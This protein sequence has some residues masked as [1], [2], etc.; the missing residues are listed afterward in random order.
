MF[1][2]LTT[3]RYLA[4]PDA[5]DASVQKALAGLPSV[6]RELRC[7]E[8]VVRR[9]LLQACDTI[10]DPQPNPPP[11]A[12]EGM[13]ARFGSVSGSLQ[14]LRARCRARHDLARMSLDRTAEE[15]STCPL[16]TVAGSSRDAAI[17][18]A[19]DRWADLF[20]A[21]RDRCLAHSLALVRVCRARGLAARLVLGVKAKPFAAHAWAQLGEAVLNDR[22][23]NVRQ[24]APIAAWP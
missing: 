10:V 15:L 16:P 23:E 19:S 7:L 20:S 24:F 4:L 5:L 18:V 3:G 14:L 17:L 6:E 11:P 1:L 21:R 13:A 2:D 22:L 12:R 9:G 8:Q